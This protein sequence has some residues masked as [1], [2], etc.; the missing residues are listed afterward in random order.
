MTVHIVVDMD[1]LPGQRDHVIEGLRA[2]V[3]PTLEEEG[4][5]RFE[6][7]VPETEENRIVLVETWA[8]QHA[9]DLHMKTEYTEA[10]LAHVK[11]SFPHAPNARRIAP[12]DLVAR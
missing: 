11:T 7:Y 6:V 5:H 8:D 4:C 12:V 2:L 3:P 9:I 1:V 10:F